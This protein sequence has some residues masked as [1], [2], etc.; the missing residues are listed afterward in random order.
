MTL[1][2]RDAPL[3]KEQQFILGLSI[4]V[5]VVL[6]L[7]FSIVGSPISQRDVSL[8]TQR[9]AN[10]QNIKYAIESSYPL[11]GLPTTFAQLKVSV[12]AASYSDTDV[13]ADPETKAPID[14]SILDSF[15]YNLCTTFSTDTTNQPLAQYNYVDSGIDDTRHAKGYD[16]I[17]YHIPEYLR[18]TPTPTAFDYPNYFYMDETPSLGSYCADIDDCQNID[19]SSYVAGS[20]TVCLNNYCQCN[21]LNTDAIY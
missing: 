1:L 12:N 9:L 19:C 16:C 18:T 5:V 8:D 2:S 17:T 7:G 13:L 15:S 14:Y 20:Q 3:S 11:D 6:G 4:L 10:F 21:G